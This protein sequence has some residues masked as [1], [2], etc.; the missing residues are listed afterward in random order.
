LLDL[1]SQG[2]LG[3][4]GLTEP[5]TESNRPPFEELSLEEFKA[6]FPEARYAFSGETVEGRQR[7][8]GTAT[9]SPMGW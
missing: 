9:P 2:E 3:D 6:P 8:S 5:V 4:L 1:K 7:P